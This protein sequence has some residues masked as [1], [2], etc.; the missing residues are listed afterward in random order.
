MIS[1]PISRSGLN[2]FFELR[3]LW[4]LIALYRR[5]RPDVVHH[6]AVKP[7]IYGSV[8]AR[9]TGVPAVVNALVGLGYVFSSTELKARLLI[10]LVRTLFK[11]ALRTPATRLI[12]QNRDDF[13]M[14]YGERL[15]RKDDIRLVRGSGVDPASIPNVTRTAR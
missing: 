7:V 1:I 6:V 4:T 11:L 15:A 2:P 13:E 10:G 5:E 3:T 12:V 14:F 8:A 9:L